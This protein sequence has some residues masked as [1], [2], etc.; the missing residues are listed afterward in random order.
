MKHRIARLIAATLCSTA[1]AAGTIVSTANGSPVDD[2]RAEAQRLQQQIDANGMKISSL[3]EQY[4]GAQIAFNEATARVDTAERRL[5]DARRS[6]LRI[7]RLVKQRAVR[8]YVSSGQ[9]TPLAALSAPN[10]RVFPRSS[11]AC[12]IG[13]GRRS[14]AWM[15]AI[16]SRGLKGLVT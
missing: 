5:A 12:P 6:T 14:M 16:S 13:R 4:N 7:E 8:L 11:G 1:F 10:I 3:G 9:A 2:K 15:R